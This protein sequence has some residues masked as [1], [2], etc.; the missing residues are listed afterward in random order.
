MHPSEVW[1]VSSRC[2][3]PHP[4]IGPLS[5]GADHSDRDEYESAVASQGHYNITVVLTST[6]KH[7][8]L[9]ELFF[10][11]PTIEQKKQ[12]ILNNT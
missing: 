9:V 12:D 7:L 5:Q 4:L 6:P 11:F 2:L 8:W 1:K 10:F 3:V